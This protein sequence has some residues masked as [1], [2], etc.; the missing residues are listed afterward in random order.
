MSGIGIAIT[1]NDN[2]KKKNGLFSGLKATQRTNNDTPLMSPTTNTQPTAEEATAPTPQPATNGTQEATSTPLTM[3]TQTTP[4]KP[5]PSQL[6]PEQWAPAFKP[7]QPSATPNLTGVDTAKPSM[8]N[9]PKPSIKPTTQPSVYNPQAFPEQDTNNQQTA[10]QPADTVNND[11]NQAQINTIA[12]FLATRPTQTTEEYQRKQERR[13]NIERISRGL[14]A[15][16]NIFTTAH[17]GV[18]TY[19]YD[20]DKKNYE[21]DEQKRYARLAQEWKDYRNNLQQAQNIA[22]KQQDIDIRKGNLL[23]RQAQQKN[24]LDKW[25]HEFDLKQKKQSSDEAYKSA[26]VELKRQQ[27]QLA[28]EKNEDNRQLIQARI[29]YLKKSLEIRRQQ[30]GVAKQNANRQGKTKTTTYTRDAKG[31]VTSSTSSYK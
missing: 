12:D 17:G 30:V 14:K 8:Y 10:Q 9:L 5:A 29:D 4:Q 2:N 18:S 22:F 23:W 16:A 1:S 13:D 3:T 11:D 7:A 6:A 28:K 15:L 31:R 19:D 20:A 21:T 24:A 27:Q 25:Q 26:Q